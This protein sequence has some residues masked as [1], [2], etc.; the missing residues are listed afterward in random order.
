MTLDIRGSLKNTRINHNYYVV[1]DELLSNAIDSFL[2]RC[3]ENNLQDDLHVEFI[4]DFFQEQ[5]FGNSINLK[6]TAI[7]NGAGFDD[8]RTKAFVTKDTTYKDDLAIDGIGTC[9]GSGRIQFLHFFKKLEIDSL[10]WDQNNLKRKTLLINETAKEVNEDSFEES[11]VNGVELATT[12]ILDSL[13]LEVLNKVFSGSQLIDVFSTVNLRQHVLVSSLQ[14]LVSLKDRLGNFEISFKTNNENLTEKSVLVP[15]DIPNFTDQKNIKVFYETSQQTTINSEENF[16]ITH[17]KLNKND[18][19]LNQNTV[20][21]C[22]KS[23]IVKNVTSRY[24][25][26]KTLINNDV[27]GFYHIV[28]IE[29]KYLDQFVNEQRDSFN[30]PQSIDE[31]SLFNKQLSMDEIYSQIDE[32][33]LDML[34]PP[35]WKKEEI[36]IK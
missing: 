21:L 19:S 20:A 3:K 9:K 33:I 12:I 32:H 4:I 17:Y 35:D 24:L 13:K 16:L 31:D 36:I 11:A 34:V 7:D 8:K 29:A 25:K 23:S 10:F 18:F 27:N 22:A 5:L 30:I 26:S 14:R 6:I 2:I 1:I 15:S 28:L